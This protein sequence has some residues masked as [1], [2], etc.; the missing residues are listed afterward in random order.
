MS[1]IFRNFT[2]PL[3]QNSRLN[4]PTQAE[5]LPVEAGL[6]PRLANPPQQRTQQSRP[7]QDALFEDIW[8]PQTFNPIP[9]LAMPEVAPLPLEAGLGPRLLPLPS[10]PTRAAYT[11]RLRNEISANALER[12]RDLERFHQMEDIS[13]NEVRQTTSPPT[14]LMS[15]INN[16]GIAPE[17][18]I[19]NTGN[20]TTALADGAELIHV[21]RTGVAPT[22]RLG[23]ALGAAGYAGIA[24]DVAAGIVSNVQTDAP[25]EQIIE[26]ALV[27]AAVGA[28]GLSLSLYVGAKVTASTGCVKTGTAAGIATGLLYSLGLDDAAEWIIRN[29]GTSSQER[30]RETVQEMGRKIF[31]NN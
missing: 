16:R 12:A 6:G 31:S 23:S 18:I 17:N 13:P 22:G 3:G 27:D 15:Q 10:D 30:M 29:I 26:D 20:I 28:G 11:T 1:N 8:Q 24:L 19:S 4:L 21:F 2:L 7:I 25:V 9:L 5:V 14:P